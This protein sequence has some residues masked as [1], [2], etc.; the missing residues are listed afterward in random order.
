M[1]YCT[2]ADLQLAIPQATLV[3]LTNDAPADYSVAPEPNLAVVEEAV[4][5]AE[6]LVDAHLRGRYVLP[7]ATVPSVIKDNT[8]NLARHWLY[9]RRPEGNE[10]PDAV[11][12]TYKAALQILES[13]R[14]GK[15]TIGLPTGE[16]APEPG[17]VKVRA[18]RQLFSATLLERY[19]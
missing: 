11:T 2:L 7:L 15:L 3:Q 12:R 13:I 17:E 4:R 1:R 5:Q 14:D 8:V 16:A 10:L 18:R 19:R 9:A 6:E